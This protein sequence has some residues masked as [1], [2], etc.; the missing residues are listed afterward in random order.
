M[1]LPSPLS[2][3]AFDVLHLLLLPG[4][5]RRGFD[6]A[7]LLGVIVQGHVLNRPVL[8][9]VPLLPRCRLQMRFQGSQNSGRIRPPP[10]SRWRVASRAPLPA[11]KDQGPRSL[12][13]MRPP[14]CS[15][16]HAPT[17]APPPANTGA[18]VLMRPVIAAEHRHGV[19]RW[20]C[21][22]IILAPLRQH[23]AACLNPRRS[24]G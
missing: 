24:A 14:P 22:H 17:P 16:Q 18:F 11:N 10:C 7:V 12:G 3:N 6:R 19:A 20:P 8:A 4:L 2:I 21:M 15:H 23:C 13:R 1:P 9:R 5:A